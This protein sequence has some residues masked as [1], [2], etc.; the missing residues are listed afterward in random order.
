MFKK[1]KHEVKPLLWIAAFFGVT[2]I[3]GL[4][5]NEVQRHTGQIHPLVFV[6]AFLTLFGLYQ[7]WLSHKETNTARQQNDWI[8][9]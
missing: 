3:I 5:L 4:G 2:R 6:A 1:Y 7:W 8:N 9:T